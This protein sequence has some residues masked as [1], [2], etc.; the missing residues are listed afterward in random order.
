VSLQAATAAILLSLVLVSAAGARPLRVMSVD[1]CSDQFVLALAPR[2]EIVGVSPHAF[3]PDAWLRKDARGL[4]VR[5]PTLEEALAAHPDIV[6]SYWTAEGR[7]ADALQAHGARVVRIEDAYDFGGVRANIRR[8][9]AA[10]GRGPQGEAMIARM[11]AKLA[12][13]RGAWGG[14]RAV[15]LTPGAFT[16]G[17]DTL[18]GAI[19]AGAGLTDAVRAPGYGPISL[20]RLTLDPPNL[21]VLGFFDDIDG[22]RWEPGRSPLVSRLAKGRTAARLPGA[23]LGCPAW[24]AADATAELAR[25]APKRGAP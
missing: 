6:V 1:Q 7:L 18:V 14:R 22:G 13:S 16:A 20:E 24:F 21:L 9:A 12:A 11:D 17:P 5:R 23:W 25:A 19:M 8:V 15:Y 2:N 10:L 3:D 4:T